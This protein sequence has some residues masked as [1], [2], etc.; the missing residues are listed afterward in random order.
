MCICYYVYTRNVFLFYY[1]LT[2]KVVTTVNVI[3]IV[4]TNTGL[5]V[6]SCTKE[7]TLSFA[8]KSGL[9]FS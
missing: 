9:Q 3:Q 7:A 4:I 6:E 1:R 2:C 5:S 8:D